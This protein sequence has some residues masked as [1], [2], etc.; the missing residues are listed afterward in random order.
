MK[1][2]RIIWE[3]FNEEKI[4]KGYHIHHIDGNRNN[5][6]PLNLMCISPEDHFKIHLDQCD[7]V[8]LSG[9]FI[10]GASD[11]G[12]KGG[13]ASGYK[14]NDSQRNNLSSILKASYIERGGSPLKGRPISES[15]KIAIGIGISGE[16]NGMYGKNHSDETKSLISK[17]RSGIQGRAPGW[18]FTE[19]QIESQKIGHRKFFE[20]GG[21]SAFSRI[22]TVVTED[23][24]TLCVKQ[25]TSEIIKILGIT[26]R[27]FKTLRV[28]CRR[29]PDRY[30]PKFN[31]KIIDEGKLYA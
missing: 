19:E 3:K 18:K 26:D 22:Y 5:N 2:Y 29:S 27:Q 12:K 1:S 11:A 31:I 25:V 14:W 9:K 20:G 15:H 10:Q 30:H 7:I 28:F 24:D 17:N 21:K 6:E 23:G 13:L 4:P 16:N 8:C